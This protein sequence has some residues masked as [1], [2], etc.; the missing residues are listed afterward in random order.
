MRIQW[1]HLGAVGGTS[2]WAEDTVDMEHK[3][4]DKGPALGTH[5]VAEVD[6]RD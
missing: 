5:T 6:L 4:A 1:D 2:S 3:R